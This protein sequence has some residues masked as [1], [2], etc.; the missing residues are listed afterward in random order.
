[1]RKKN[2]L[3]TYLYEYT[4][5]IRSVLHFVLMEQR[6]S[7]F[8]TNCAALS[9]E[10][11]AKYSYA[12]T[13]QTARHA[14]SDNS[15]TQSISLSS[16]HPTCGDPWWGP[17]HSSE[18]PSRLTRRLCS[19]ML[20][21]VV[22][23]RRRVGRQRCPTGTSTPGFQGEPGNQMGIASR[24]IPP[25]LHQY[26]SSCKFFQERC[27]SLLR[28][29]WCYCLIVRLPEFTWNTPPMAIPVGHTPG[30][31]LSPITWIWAATPSE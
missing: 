16:S 19:S 29:E 9:P 27:S 25:G 8:W 17:T 28:S 21:L 15:D 2:N 23:Q 18:L 13:L 12:C 7:W 20:S 31:L 11:P 5:P 4:V 14:D 24:E 1:M 6:I 30:S 3:R 10:F 22:A 26:T